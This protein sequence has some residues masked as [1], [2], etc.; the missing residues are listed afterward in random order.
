MPPIWANAVSGNEWYPKRN[1]TKVYASK[2]RIKKLIIESDVDF[3]E[4][5]QII[6]N[7][8]KNIEPT[9]I[10]NIKDE[11]DKKWAIELIKNSTAILL[12]LLLKLE[13]IKNSDF[14]HIITKILNINPKLVESI[15]TAGHYYEFSQEWRSDEE[16]KFREI[17]GKI[18]SW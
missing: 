14:E 9:H 11:N 12:R 6:F 4:L 1:L 17:M 3:T 2:E 16:K 5:L 18:K 15:K 10:N 13:V 7:F 8:I